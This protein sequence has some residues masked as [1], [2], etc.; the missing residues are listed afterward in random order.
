MNIRFV[1]G[2]LL[3]SLMFAL[4]GLSDELPRRSI[5]LDEALAMSAKSN[6]QLRI[7][8]AQYDEA[9]GQNLE[10][11]SGFLPHF[12]ISEQFVKS[13]DPVTV[14]GLK[15]KQGVFAETDFALSSLNAPDA[16]EN[17]TTEFKIEL[18]L[19]NLD[20]IFGKAAA[21]MMAK[22]KQQGVERTRQAIAH[23][24]RA[25][26]FGLI[27]TDQ[28]RKAIDEALKSAQ[29]HRDDAKAAYEQG[30]IS[31]AE[32]LAAEVRLAEL[33]EQQLLA[34]NQVQNASDALRLILG[35]EESTILQPTDTLSHIALQPENRK[36][37]SALLNRADLQ[38]IHFY[39]KAASRNLLAK[40]SAWLP[41]LNAFGMQEWNAADAFAK[42]ADN[43]TVG[44]RLSWQLFDGLGHFG[45]RKQ[46]AAQKH[47]ASLQLQ[48][49]TQQA[50]NEIGAAQRN[51]Q[52]AEKRIAVAEQGVRQAKQSLHITE[53][54]YREGLEKTS[55]L[56][57]R[58]AMFTNA[59]LRLLKAKHDFQLAVSQLNF[60]TGQ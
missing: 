16:F 48:Q 8:Q 57:D 53:Q 24:T 29:A 33:Q 26:Y 13:D 1:I 19:I 10:A 58:E 18:P 52:V 44:V 20:A 45:R 60:A 59:K 54:R 22:A 41:R 25:A 2:Y 39:Q 56:L 46:A 42:D 31:Q 14:F 51:L 3:F 34:E 49:A 6:Y 55:D 5:S 15:L 27:L 40:S 23:Q 21:G 4:T 28:S 7:A 37:E 50:R 17:Y 47:Q 35:M 9:K 30:I 38:A 32:Y 12:T 36:F 11:W 43:Y